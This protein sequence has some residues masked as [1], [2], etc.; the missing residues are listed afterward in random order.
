MKFNPFIFF[1]IVSTQMFHNHFFDSSSEEGDSCHYR[2]FDEENSLNFLEPNQEDRLVNEEDILGTMINSLEPLPNH[3]K[4]KEAK[5]PITSQ[6]FDKETSIG[7]SVSPFPD[8]S[9]KEEE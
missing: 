2:M 4:N 5:V 8:I 9:Q 7:F 6:G 1:I 3:S